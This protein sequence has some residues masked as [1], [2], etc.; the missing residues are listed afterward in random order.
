MSVERWIRNSYSGLRGKVRCKQTRFCL[1]RSTRSQFFPSSRGEQHG[2]RREQRQN[3]YNV[4][5]VTECTATDRLFLSCY[6]S[7]NSF[8]LLCFNHLGIVCIDVSPSKTPP[9]LFRQP[10]PLKPANFPSAPFLCNSSL[11]IGFS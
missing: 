11:Y 9:L 5:I 3:L 6:V 7:V 4:L 10:P 2:G 8:L 1:Q